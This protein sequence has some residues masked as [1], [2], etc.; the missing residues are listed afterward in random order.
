MKMKEI[1]Q[2]SLPGIPMILATIAA[3]V[4]ACAVGMAGLA[5]EQGGG[6]WLVVAILIIGP[7][8]LSAAVSTWSSPTRP[9]C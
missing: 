7:A 2:R 9:R 3:I 8:S 6:Q 5:A 4:L 1:T